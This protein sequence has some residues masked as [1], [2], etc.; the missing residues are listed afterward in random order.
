MAIP[1]SIATNKTD[2]EP[3]LA[4]KLEAF[5]E[6]VSTGRLVKFWKTTQDLELGVVKAL[7]KALAE[8]P[9]IGWIRGDAAASE[10]LLVKVNSLYSE[11]ANLRAEN[12][13]LVE[14][15]KPRLD[16]IAGL[17]EKVNVRFRIREWTG[18]FYRP[19][20][21]RSYTLTWAEIFAAVGPGLFRPT[22]PVIIDTSL[23]RHLQENKGAKDSYPELFDSDKNLIK[24]HLMALGLIEIIAAQDA[25]G[26]GVSE[27][28]SLTPNGKRHLLELL[29]VRGSDD[30]GSAAGLNS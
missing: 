8:M 17:H 1:G 6:K 16:G 22:S 13:D 15:S 4:A 24:V 30:G 27:F 28:A 18:Q 11:V 26:T 5:R 12:M 10:D 9:G 2:T 19:L 7:A 25:Q 3:A 20:G 21:E 14:R 29:A 23:V